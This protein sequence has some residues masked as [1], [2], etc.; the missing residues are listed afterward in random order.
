M[1][2]HGG[3]GGMGG[4]GMN[5]GAGPGMLANVADE[6]GAAYDPRLARRAL[7][8]VGPFKL[9]VTFVLLMTVAQASL[10]TVG[11]VLTKIAIDNHIAPPN[12]DITGATIF[13]GLTILAYF[14]AFLA[15]W[16]Q[17]QVMTRVG[18]RM[19][20]QMRGDMIRHIQRLPLTYFDSV[21][22]GVVV[23][24]VI[25]DVQTVNELLSNGIVQ[26]L[27][28][29]LTLGFTVA[30]MVL[31][32]PNLAVVTFAV[33][34]LMVGAVWIFTEKAKVAYRRSRV[35][36]ATLTGEF[37]E[38]Y[39]GVR[40]VQ[41]FAREAS[42]QER[43]DEVNN[44]NRLANIQANTLSSMLLP[45]VEL[46][47]A[48]ATVSVIAYGGW[49]M[50]NGESSLGVLVAFLAYIT[51]FFQPIRTLTQFYNQLQAATA[52][53]EKVFELLDEP[54]T[55]KE[56]P[57]PITLGHVRG[58]VEFRDVAF[59]Y[60]REPVLEDV[61]FHADPGE[62]I[63]M[64]GH[65]GAGKTT[66][67]SLLSRFYDPVAGSI[68]LD[69]YDLRDLSFKTLR[70]SIGL[71]LQDNFLFSGTVA[72]N[73]RYGRPT[74]THQEVEAAARVA[75]ADEFIQRLPLG[76]AT[77]VLERAANL[78]LGQRQLIAI[79]R[80][81]LANP[82]VLIL[83]EA[84]SNIDSQTELLVQRALHKLLAGRTSL[85][86]AHRLSTIRA[87]DEVLVLDAGR[88]VERGNH[89]DLLRKRG[90]YFELYQQQFAELIPA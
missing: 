29:I 38:S 59:S 36:V 67:A 55:I 75:N 31:L 70:Q 43:F 85:V 34:P 9:D 51:R 56:A 81:V 47:N 6:D 48:A 37:A 3:G 88:I 63:A 83:D 7:A 8:Y 20:Q 87:A 40:V 26:A 73:I 57:E 24:R 1:M 52:A 28:D 53:A 89:N 82:R 17:M 58:E 12:T 11:P 33:M 23:S 49:L 13:L 14:L 79:A 54:V 22:A 25:N 32:A 61:S 45:V 16:A 66:I 80:A 21:P 64:V 41:A 72:D 86:I 76:Y 60:G 42:S 90:Y 27:S 62:M 69:G 46:C 5:R 35:T 15:N 19:L 30:V 50:V 71:V 2:M 74:A 78:S 18:Q 84:T 44:D 65:T 68:M 4:G 39:A 10:M 77:P